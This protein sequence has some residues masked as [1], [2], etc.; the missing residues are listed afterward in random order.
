MTFFQ[1]YLIVTSAIFITIVIWESKDFDWQ[2]F[3][4]QLKELFAKIIVKLIDYIVLSIL[5]TSKRNRQWHYHT[6]RTNKK[7]K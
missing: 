3:W 7:G 1:L 6:Q 5:N 2:E 4:E